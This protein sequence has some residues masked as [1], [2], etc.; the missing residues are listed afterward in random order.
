[1]LYLQKVYSGFNLNAMFRVNDSLGFLL[2][3]AA[4][5][6]VSRFGQLMKEKG[7]EL[8]HG[9]WIVLSRLWEEDGLNQQ[10]ISERSNVAKPNISTY[11]DALEKE[12]YLLRTED[13][14]DRRN[15]RL[16]L[17]DKGKSLKEPCQQ[18]AIQSNEE[19]LSPL[20]DAEKRELLRLLKKIR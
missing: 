14:E 15:Y 16:Y 9:G 18:I 10:Q 12:G 2:A 19:T 1:M 4:K 3:M 20:N 17:T 11:A 5:K 8:G 7:I 13:Q 6:T